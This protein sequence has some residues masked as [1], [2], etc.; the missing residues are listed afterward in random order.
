MDKQI[1][2]I[3]NLAVK[4]IEMLGCHKELVRE[5]LNHISRIFCIVYLK[6]LYKK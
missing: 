4:V 3:R 1:E 6:Y 2:G 5:T